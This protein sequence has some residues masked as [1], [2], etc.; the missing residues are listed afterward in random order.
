MMDDMTRR[1][2]VVTRT[3]A[4]ETIPFL[5]KFNNPALII[6]RSNTIKL[7]YITYL[8]S[9]SSRTTLPF[10]IVMTRFPTESITPLL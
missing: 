10:S 8:P 5:L 7:N 2:M 3:E 4:H 6:L 1:V 9:L